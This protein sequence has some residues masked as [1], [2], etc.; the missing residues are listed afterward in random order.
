L[1]SHQVCLVL[2]GG[3]LKLSQ[4]DYLSVNHSLGRRKHSDIWRRRT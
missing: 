2:R 3:C 1:R 4:R